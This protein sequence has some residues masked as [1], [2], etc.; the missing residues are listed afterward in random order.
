MSKKK[1]MVMEMSFDYYPFSSAVWEISNEELHLDI[2]KAK[3]KRNVRR[4]TRPT[5]T[6]TGQYVII[7]IHQARES[8]IGA[9][10][11]FQR[12]NPMCSSCEEER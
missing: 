4:K 1:E 7:I 6:T 2:T 9:P 5:P 10:M 11:Q 8:E 12:K 3:W